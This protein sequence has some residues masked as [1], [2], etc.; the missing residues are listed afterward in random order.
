MALWVERLNCQGES[1]EAI[2]GGAG[3]I[4]KTLSKKRI[5]GVAVFRKNPLRAVGILGW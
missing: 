1:V 3:E 5:H 4:V 2:S